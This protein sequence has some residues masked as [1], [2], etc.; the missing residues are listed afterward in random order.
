[1]SE[2]NVDVVRKLYELF[3]RRDLDAAFPDYAD[4]SIE[5]RVPPLYP[6]TPEVFRGREGI[7]RW[8]AMIDEVWAEWR[9]ELE[10]Y[11]EAGSTVVV[12][13]RLIAEGGSSG[14]HLEREV[15]HLWTFEGGRATS[16]RV[17]LNQAEALGA[18]GL[19]E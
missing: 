6:D 19:R 2:E 3:A 5:L 7:E 10:R 11:L 18:A 15:A 16:I 1:M 8:I 17:Y 9:F 12:L 4:P 13:A 14:I